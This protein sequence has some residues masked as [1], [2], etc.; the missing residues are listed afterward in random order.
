MSSLA[1]ALLD[2]LD[3][4]ALDALAEKLASRLA[5]PAP[6]GWL[7]GAQRIAEYID[8]PTSRVYALT[9][10][11]SIPCERDGSHLIA[12]KSDLD[13]WLRAGGATRP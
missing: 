1:T 13:R 5:V 2:A 7:R 8:A 9:S 10:A 3:D 6:D 12:R 4:D 11:R